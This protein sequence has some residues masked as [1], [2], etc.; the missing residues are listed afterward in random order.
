MTGHP[1]W[2][3]PSYFVAIVALSFG[4]AWSI[5][6]VFELQERADRAE[7]AVEFL[8]EREPRMPSAW[9]FRI[10]DGSILDCVRADDEQPVYLCQRRPD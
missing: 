5:F 10:E 9:T 4:V 3:W 6:Q 2:F 7:T 8:T 1:R